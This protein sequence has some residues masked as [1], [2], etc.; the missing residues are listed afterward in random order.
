M[1]DKHS[2]TSHRNQQEFNAESVMVTVIRCPEFLVHKKYCGIWR[3]NEDNLHHRVV[4]GHK[5]CEKIKI[6]CREDDCKHDLRFAR[7]SC[8]K[9]NFYGMLT[10]SQT[11]DQTTNQ[12]MT[13]TS[14]HI[15]VPQSYRTHRPSITAASR[16]A[17]HLCQHRSSHSQIYDIW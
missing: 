9:T 16:H 5:Y 10:T 11:I 8:N 15:M 1:I 12:L 13:D 7:Q 17:L 4:N 2:K 14:C 6:T 3:C